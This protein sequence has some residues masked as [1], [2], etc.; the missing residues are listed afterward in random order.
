MKK[1]KRSNLSLIFL[2]S[3]KITHKTQFWRFVFLAIDAKNDHVLIAI[4]NCTSNE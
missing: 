3:L 4:R 1:Q 2:N